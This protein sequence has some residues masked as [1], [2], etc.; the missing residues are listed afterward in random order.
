VTE[1]HVVLVPLLNP[2]ETEAKVTSI[3]VSDG[4]LVRPGD[5]ILTLET[6]KTSVELEAEWEGFVVGLR[7]GLGDVVR[8]GEVL[9]VIAPGPDWEPPETPQ[10]RVA[11]PGDETPS[12]L[13]ITRP[14][15]ET[16][17][18]LGVDLATLPHGPLVTAEFVRDL[19]AADSGS[20]K[21]ASET[22]A[23]DSAFIYGGGGHGRTLLEL[24]RSASSHRVVGFVDDGLTPGSEILGV[25]VVGRGDDLSGLVTRG[26]RIALN[27][28]GGVADTDARI[29]VWDK[30]VDAGFVCP[31]LVHPSAHVE[32]SATVEAG[33]QVLAH[34][35]V[36]SEATV[37]VNSI[38]NTGV[39]VSHHVSVGA[40]CHIAPGALL[41][42]NVEV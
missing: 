11:S 26:M 1:T 35:Y 16:A 4:T 32:P 18:D 29:R 21:A 10:S 19:A 15:L 7:A 2:N 8:A 13:R 20:T 38:I 24:V 6:T 23:T 34:A 27:G 30:L 12:G 33:G 40:H 37:G 17:R 39:V 3:E 22:V 9:Y 42:G 14:A 25:E 5:P 28:V 36:G 31:A 41:A